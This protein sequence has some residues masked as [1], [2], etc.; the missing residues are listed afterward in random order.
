MRKRLLWCAGSVAGAVAAWL[1]PVVP[2]WAA[3]GVTGFAAGVLL[4]YGL[5][6]HDNPIEVGVLAV[7]LAV[8]GALLGNAGERVAERARQLREERRAARYNGGITLPRS[9]P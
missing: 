7:I 9:C 3:G 8:L 2:T 1:V 6:G 5:F 4:W